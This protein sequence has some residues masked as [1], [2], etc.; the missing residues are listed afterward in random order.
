MTYKTNRLIVS[1]IAG[2]ALLVI[3][4]F[5]A[6]GSSAPVDTDL[7]SWAK[8][9]FKFIVIGVVSQ[10]IIQIIFHIVY[11]ISIGVKNGGTEDRN[12][13]RTIESS[14]IEDEM[15]K[16][17]SLKSNVPG[18]TCLGLGLLIALVAVAYFEC[19]AVLMLNIIFI[20]AFVSMLAD[21]SASIYYY[22]KGV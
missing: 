5:Y 20:S 10:I 18:L 7:A 9:M 22:H 19:T 13:E 4:I 2:I 8:L 16:L 1:L 11:A 15:D 14:S 12:V 3:Y 6:T 21:A 17:I